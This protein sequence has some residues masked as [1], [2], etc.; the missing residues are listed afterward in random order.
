MHDVSGSVIG[1]GVHVALTYDASVPLPTPWPAS[2]S[3][4]GVVAEQGS[5]DSVHSLFQ[6]H[7][8]RDNWDSTPWC[9]N[10]AWAGT[11][12]LNEV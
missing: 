12:R 6:L 11:V 4:H 9:L 8:M 5:G 1:R 7:N 2:C 10:H 3:G